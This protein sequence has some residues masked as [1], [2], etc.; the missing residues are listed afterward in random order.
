MDR[1][2]GGDVLCREG[3]RTHLST[4]LTM[5]PEP[6][7]QGCPMALLVRSEKKKKKS[8]WPAPTSNILT[9][10]GNQPYH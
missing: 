4:L 8:P 7:T 10:Y 2:G 9:Y 5:M 6:V 1:G 3:A